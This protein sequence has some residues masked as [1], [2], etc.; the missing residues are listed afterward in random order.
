MSDDAI[1]NKSG[2]GL[3]TTDRVLATNGL[4][5]S[6]VTILTHAIDMNGAASVRPSLLHSS[7]YGTVTWLYFIHYMIVCISRPIS[8]LVSGLLSYG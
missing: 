3:E 4:Y 6:R 2:N 1:L 7:H 8:P 5:L